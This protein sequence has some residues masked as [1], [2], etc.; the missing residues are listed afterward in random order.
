MRI[1]IKA[2]SV[3]VCLY[4]CNCER[5]ADP[6]ESAKSDTRDQV[7]KEE[8]PT[9]ETY[10][11][12]TKNK[13]QKMAEI[14]QVAAKHILVSSEQEAND[15]LE[16]IKNVNDNLT[17]EE[18]AKKFSKCPSRV[19]GGDLGFFGRNM[20]VKEFET[21]AFNLNKGEISEPVQTQFGWHLIQVYDKK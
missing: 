10:N 8:K 12:V 3:M 17:F 9:V 16:R 4:C 5:A 18:A 21:V 19:E 14:S 1:F 2:L 6:K 7:A 20:M 11:Q 15:L 13:E